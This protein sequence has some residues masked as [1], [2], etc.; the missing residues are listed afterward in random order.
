MRLSSSSYAFLSN[1]GSLVGGNGIV[2]YKLNN[3]T[4]LP[5]DG[6]RAILSPM[7]SMVRQ[8]ATLIFSMY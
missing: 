4:I 8:A 6:K 2:Y 1:E 7:L 3:K 5:E